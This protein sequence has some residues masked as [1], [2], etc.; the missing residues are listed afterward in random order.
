MVLNP[1]TEFVVTGLLT[2]ASGDKVYHPKCPYCK[3]KLTVLRKAPDDEM[4]VTFGCDH[5][6]GMKGPGHM[7]TK[8]GFMKKRRRRKKTVGP[9]LFDKE[10]SNVKQGEDGKGRSGSERG[11]AEA[12]GESVDFSEW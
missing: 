2:Y 4:I 12:C 5:Y 3:K 10:I 1:G 9:T 8:G 7:F 11:M 6:E